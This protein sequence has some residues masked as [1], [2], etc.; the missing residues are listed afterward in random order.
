[1][2]K[3]E[4]LLAEA[5][6]KVYENVEHSLG[7]VLAARYHEGKGLDNETLHHVLEEL[8]E[9]LTDAQNDPDP[10]SALSSLISKLKVD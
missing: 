10:S 8:E 4:Q 6:K 1:M 2:K 3:D 9:I 5:Y 7:N